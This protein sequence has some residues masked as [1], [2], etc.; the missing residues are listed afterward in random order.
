M[1]Q[2]ASNGSAAAASL[3]HLN[4]CWNKIGVWGNRECVE[5]KKATHCRN[6]S[7]YSSAAAQLLGA[8]LPAD[9][10]RQWAEHFAREARV[11]SAVLHSALLF[12]VGPEWL[13][14]S[15]RNLQ[16]VADW[17]PIHSLPPGRNQSLVGLAN[18]RGELLVCVS[19]ERALGLEKGQVEKLSSKRTSYRRM[20]VAG[21]QNSRFVFPVD[22]VHGMHWFD[23]TQLKGV[24]STVSKAQ[25]LYIRGILPWQGKSVGCLDDPALLEMLNR[26]LT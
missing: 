26:S 15:T 2:S 14:L 25:A 1:N 22:E 5:L 18:I 11:E 4:D 21:V 3:V 17:R 8:E 12:R 6:C 9:Y 20:V 19:L 13:A 16:E 10:L 7:V 23:P 24:P